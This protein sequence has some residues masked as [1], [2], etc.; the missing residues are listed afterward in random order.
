MGIKVLWE[1]PFTLRLFNFFKKNLPNFFLLFLSILFCLV[2]L[3]IYLHFAPLK[4]KQSRE[5]WV[6]NLEFYYQVHLNSDYF[7]DD[8]FKIEKASNV[9]R[10]F[11]IG[12]SFV[13]G[14]GV[15]DD[16]TID[17]LLEKK[18]NSRNLPYRYEVFNLGIIGID[19]PQYYKLAKQF[20]K[21][22]PDAV[23]VSFYVDN[24]VRADEW[25]HRFYFI[26][27]FKSMKELVD[28]FLWKKGVRDCFFQDIKKYRDSSNQEYIRL[29]CE[30]KINPHLFNRGH[31]PDQY[32]HY[33]KLAKIFREDHYTSSFLLGI[34]KL[35]FPTP[36][37]ILIQPSKYQVSSEYFKYLKPLG[38]NFP[39][40]KLLGREMQD[41]VLEWANKKS[42]NALDVLPA[43]Q[44]A[45]DKHFYYQ[46]DDH[47]NSEGNDFM[48]TLL[49]NYIE[50]NWD[51]RK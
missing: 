3:E 39:N 25:K 26:D 17:K 31:I 22:H 14:A 36:V 33:Q 6:E 7:R 18:L 51:N 45:T 40:G 41:V 44:A 35:F 47:Y 42:V 8:E 24:D 37:L 16:E 13:Y 21:Y 20:K 50:N 29:A 15:D 4:A 43:M 28:V 1:H 49:A 48:A 9:Y 5:L 2:A 27:W 23:I 46:I 34:Q 32:L 12:D 10:I 38:F 30:G 19:L 11:L